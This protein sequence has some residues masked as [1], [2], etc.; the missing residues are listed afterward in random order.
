MIYVT[1]L[2]KHICKQVSIYVVLNMIS[3]KNIF[4]PLLCP[5]HSHINLDEHRKNLKFLK[6]IQICPKLYMENRGGNLQSYK[7]VYSKIQKLMGV[8]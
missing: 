4:H 5:I 2:P 3:H 1:Y 8:K 6:E 7:I